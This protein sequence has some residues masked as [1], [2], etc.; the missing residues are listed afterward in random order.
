MKQ[1]QWFQTGI[2]NSKTMGG[3]S[4]PKRSCGTFDLILFFLGQ[5]DG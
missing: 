2:V 3:S 5:E 4:D 1:K